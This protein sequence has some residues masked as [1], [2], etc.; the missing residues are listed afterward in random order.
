MAEQYYQAPPWAL[1]SLLSLGVLTWGLA[2]WLERRSVVKESNID[3]A[4]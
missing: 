3:Q 1:W 4:H 2:K